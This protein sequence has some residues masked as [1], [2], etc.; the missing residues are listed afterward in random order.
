MHS[1]NKCCTTAAPTPP[2]SKPSAASGSTRTAATY[3]NLTRLRATI[4]SGSYRT[5]AHGSSRKKAEQQAA[6][7]LL[8][9]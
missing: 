2:S 1:P 8:A 3:P 5:T 9:Q 4:V 6:A 7:D